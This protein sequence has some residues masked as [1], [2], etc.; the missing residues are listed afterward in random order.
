MTS[1]TRADVKPYLGQMSNV[2][3]DELDG[4]VAAAE[5]AVESRVGPL[6]VSAQSSV[7]RGRGTCELV[8]P[9]VPIDAVTS[10]TGKSGSTVT[11]DRFS[12]R[13]GVIYFETALSE[14]YYTVVYTAGWAATAAA[15]PADLKQA[16][17]W[18]VQLDWQSMRGKAQRG[19]D[20]LRARI[21]EKLGPYMGH[22]FA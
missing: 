20:D 18:Q 7:V 13:A 1:L 11:V 5:A 22:G 8:V 12:G 9:V 19:P 16:V 10:V 15:I 4:F 2:N 21:A 17:G 3:D 6:V 14:D